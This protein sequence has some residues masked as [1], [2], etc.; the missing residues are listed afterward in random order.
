MTNET[1]T[2]ETTAAVGGSPLEAVV[3]D[4]SIDY[5]GGNC[6]VQAEGTINGMPF[7]FRARGNMWSFG[8]GDDPVGAAMGLAVGWRA[9]GEYGESYD[10][11]WMSEDDAMRIINRCATEYMTANN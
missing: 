9:T 10:A 11:S 6:P 4:L 8:A 5:L 3:S 2:V 7:Y 1:D